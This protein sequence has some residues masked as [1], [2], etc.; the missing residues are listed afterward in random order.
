MLFGF[1]LM[2]H[3]LDELDDALL[4]TIVEKYKNDIPIPNDFPSVAK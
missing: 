1:Y 2:S 4:E 3:Y